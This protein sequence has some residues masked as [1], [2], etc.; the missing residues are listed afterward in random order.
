MDAI[1]THCVRKKV[2]QGIFSSR[3]ISV[4]DA[5][6]LTILVYKLLV[7]KLGVIIIILYKCL[8]LY[9]HYHHYYKTL[10]ICKMC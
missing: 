2:Y 5:L 3:Y 10:F 4:Y 7:L 6:S 8:F 1:Y 9:F